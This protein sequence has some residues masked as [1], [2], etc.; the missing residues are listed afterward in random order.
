LE[1]EEAKALVNAMEAPA[2]IRVVDAEWMIKVVSELKTG[3]QHGIT[4]IAS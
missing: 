1:N 4:N 2:P 3:V